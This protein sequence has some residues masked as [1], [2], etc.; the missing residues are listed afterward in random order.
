[1]IKRFIIVFILLSILVGG[2][3]WFQ[4]FRSKILKKVFDEMKQETPSINTIHTKKEKWIEEIKAIG[5]FTSVQGVTLSAEESGKVVKINFESGQAVQK[6][7]LLAQQDITVELSKLKSIQTQLDLAEITFRRIQ[8]LFEKEAATQAE[9]DDA[10]SKVKQTQAE[11]DSLKSTI[12]HKTLIAPFTGRLG[13]RLI[14]VG[15]FLTPGTPVV[16]LQALDPIYIEFGIPQNELGKIKV[17]QSIEVNV[18]AFTSEIFTG[19]ITAIEPQ[20]D[21]ATRNIRIQATLKNSE[22]KLRPGMFGSI[23]ILLNQFIEGIVVPQT[24]IQYAPYGDSVFI[25]E[26]MKD[27]KGK[28]YQGVRQQIVKL[29]RTKGDWIFISEGLQEEQ[30]VATSGVFKLRPSAEIMINPISILEPSKNP[31]PVNQ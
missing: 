15:Q 21:I 27:Q 29:G 23:R 25:V 18:D 20:I 24:A 7:D 8:S 3:F 4:D 13:I 14:Q 17:G 5:T 26:E 31:T 9:L 2:V 19:N 30:E 11:Y 10:N 1:M 6:G 12:S 16:S 22:E 28:S